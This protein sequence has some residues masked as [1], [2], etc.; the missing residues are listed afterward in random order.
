MCMTASATLQTRNELV[1]QLQLDK[2]YCS[3][4]SSLNRPNLFFSVVMLE[5]VSKSK[6]KN[7]DDFKNQIYA[8]DFDILNRI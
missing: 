4:Q 3:F 1:C 8:H 6:C 5:K 7:S 2:N